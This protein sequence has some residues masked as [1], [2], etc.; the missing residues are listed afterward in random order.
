M[1]N[2]YERERERERERG[3]SVQ[4]N[5]HMQHDYLLELIQ[6]STMAPHQLTSPLIFPP[7]PLHFYI[8]IHFPLYVMFYFPNSFQVF[9]HSP[10]PH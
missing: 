1:N 7:L 10:T 3:W 5:Q 8:F 4:L 2:E 6:V 9:K